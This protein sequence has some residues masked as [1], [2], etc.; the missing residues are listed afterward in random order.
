MALVLVIIVMGLCMILGWYTKDADKEPKH[1]F[2]EREKYQGRKV[3][4]S[5]KRINRYKDPE[6]EL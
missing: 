1:N 6:T 5:S 3:V 2:D 4:T